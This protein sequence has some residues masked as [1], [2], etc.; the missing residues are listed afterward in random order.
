MNLALGF[1]LI[2]FLIP[3]S[4]GTLLLGGKSVIGSLG[5]VVA[6]MF[7]NGILTFC[8]IVGMKED[9]T[10]WG[11]FAAGLLAAIIFNMLFKFVL[12]KK[13]LSKR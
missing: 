4:Y 12:I 6:G 3:A 7:V 5:G 8:W 9:V 11:G 1:G 2:I 10:G 13:D